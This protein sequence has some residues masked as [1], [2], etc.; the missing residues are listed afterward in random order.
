LEGYGT[1]T[2]AAAAAEAAAPTPFPPLEDVPNSGPSGRIAPGGLTRLLGVSV[3]AGVGIGLLWHL[4]GRFIDLVWIFPFAFGGLLGLCL[5]TAVRKARSRSPL[6]AVVCGVLACAAV[7]LSR[8]TAN[9]YQAPAALL[10]LSRMSESEIHAAADAGGRIKIDTNMDPVTRLRAYLDLMAKTGIT[11]KSVRSG[12]TRTTYTGTGY[13]LFLL[14]TYGI[15]GVVGAIMAASA[16]KEPYCEACDC[17]KLKTR[18][19][20]FDPSQI[21]HVL[22]LVRAQDW[23]GLRRLPAEP[24]GN[25]E[26]KFLDVMLHHC[27]GCQDAVVHV[28]SAGTTSLAGRISVESAAQA[29]AAMASPFVPSEAPVAAG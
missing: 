16:S 22:P 2:A 21:G 10:T 3:A 4:I 27:D 25:N 11:T 9:A 12:R 29:K 20:R 24:A 14:G 6:A 19:F 1:P 17:W 13:W 5:S 18:L 23:A 15:V 8:L 28:A 26:K 7:A